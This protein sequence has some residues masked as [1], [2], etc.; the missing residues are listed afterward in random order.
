MVF[1]VK[2][3]LPAVCTVY[4]NL[5]ALV[6]AAQK[7][8]TKHIGLQQRTNGW[9][10][11]PPLNIIILTMQWKVICE[12]VAELTLMWCQLFMEEVQSRHTYSLWTYCIEG[13]ILS[14]A[15]LSYQSLTATAY[16]CILCCIVCCEKSKCLQIYR[17]ITANKAHL[18]GI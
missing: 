1:I 12:P 15:H 3:I 7:D 9:I 13:L 5:S 2:V 6:A 17:R 11:N 8:L 14:E 18:H 10:L 16:V 4:I